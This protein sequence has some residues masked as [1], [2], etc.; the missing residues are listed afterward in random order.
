L[1]AIHVWT[2]ALTHNLPVDIVFLD[3]AKAFDTV[4][5]ERLLT[6]IESLGITKNCLLWIRNFLTDRRQRAVINGE[7]YN[8][9]NVTSVV[10]QGSVLGPLLFSMFVCDIPK[11]LTCFT[12]MFADDTKVF[13]I[14][15]EL[16]S[17]Q[18]ELQADLNSL[19][20]WANTMQMLFHPLKCK[21]MHLGS[22]NPNRDYVMTTSS[23]HQHIL[24]AVTE[25]KDLGIT[26]DRYLKFSKHVTNQVNGANQIHGVIKHT[27]STIDKENFLPL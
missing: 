14:I 13:E 22:R 21:V 27:F 12:S 26:I 23:G 8:W 24:D 7:L 18:S 19:Q 1:E 17:G 2:E 11:L 16:T 6:Q 25:E 4:P 9:A 3:Y 5:H 15:H 10:P 20:D